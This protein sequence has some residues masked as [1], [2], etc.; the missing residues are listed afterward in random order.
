MQCDVTYKV[1]CKT[2]DGSTLRVSQFF[3]G[4][5]ANRKSLN[6]I[7][8]GNDLHGNTAKSRLYEILCRNESKQQT[9]VIL[10]TTTNKAAKCSTHVYNNSLLLTAAMKQY[11]GGYIVDGNVCDVSGVKFETT[12]DS[13]ITIND[14][15]HYLPYCILSLPLFL[16]SF[17]F[18]FY[19]PIA[20]KEEGRGA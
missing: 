6:E 12:F 4:R 11:N 16:L 13:A 9:R 15:S 5:T 19:S 2:L 18:N 3:L 8:V 20:K 10:S 7:Y 17:F 14:N 1:T